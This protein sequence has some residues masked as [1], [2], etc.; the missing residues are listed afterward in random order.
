VGKPP[1]KWALGR[2]MR[3]E[4]TIKMNLREI[5]YEDGTG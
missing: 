3:W 1:G 2:L 4:E 5:G